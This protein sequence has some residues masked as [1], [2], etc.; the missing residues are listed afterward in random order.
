MGKSQK[1]ELKNQFARKNAGNLR[2]RTG[3]CDARR[4]YSCTYDACGRQTSKTDMYGTAT[5][6]YD[7]LGETIVNEE[8]TEN[9]IKYTGEFFDE[10]AGLYYL[11]ARYYNPGTGRFISED[12]NRGDVK[13]P[14]SLN[15]QTLI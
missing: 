1:T 2:N 8:G 11:R 14:A 13:N 7:A 4:E 12:T 3:M 9:S 6:E 10:S 15:L 5:Y